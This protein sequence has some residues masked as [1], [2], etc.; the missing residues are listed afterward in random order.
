MTDAREVHH[1]CSILSPKVGPEATRQQDIYY[2]GPQKD[3]RVLLCI[4]FFD[5]Q[6]PIDSLR[7]CESLPHTYQTSFFLNEVLVKSFRTRT[8][9]QSQHNTFEKGTQFHLVFQIYV[10]VRLGHKYAKQK[11]LP[12]LIKKGFAQKFMGCVYGH[13]MVTI[14]NI[15]TGNFSIFWATFECF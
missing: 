2:I 14:N 1:R 15:V 7:S 11:V 9:T 6:S 5:L 3:S 13:H 4:N 10:I 8:P 12:H